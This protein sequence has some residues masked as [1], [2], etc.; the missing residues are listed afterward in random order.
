M[1]NSEAD[2]SSSCSEGT[3]TNEVCMDT[4]NMEIFSVVCQ[5][6]N[7]MSNYSTLKS[8]QEAHLYMLVETWLT[9]GA[10]TSWNGELSAMQQQ[11]MWGK[12]LPHV[13]SLK[14]CTQGQQV[15]ASAAR[16]GGSGL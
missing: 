15:I 13:A 11:G 7:G 6:L 1:M 5:N 10:Q 8:R 14:P 9:G 16:G 4:H 3:S 2:S 12:A